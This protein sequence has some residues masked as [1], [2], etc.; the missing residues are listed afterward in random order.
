MLVPPPPR[1]ADAARVEQSIAAAALLSAARVV[2][3]LRRALL[4]SDWDVVGTVIASARTMR[5][6][7][8]AEREIG[9]AF[10]EWSYRRAT[11]RKL[12][13]ALAASGCLAGPI[14]QLDVDAIETA[15]LSVAVRGA[16]ALDIGG[17]AEQVS[18]LFMYRYI[19]RNHAHH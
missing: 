3:Q 13:E 8:C 18:V 17:D 12:E 5:L 14:G 7:A 6:P 15:S 16:L 4:A 9:A 11:Q 1:V 19:F 10:S 2:Y